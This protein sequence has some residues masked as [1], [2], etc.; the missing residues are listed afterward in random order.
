MKELKKLRYIG[1]AMFTMGFPFAQY[2]RTRKEAQDF[3][4]VIYRSSSGD[5]SRRTRIDRLR[6]AGVHIGR[7]AVQ[8]E[9][10]AENSGVAKT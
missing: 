8:F 4:L 10:F 5:G 7:V 1:W 3:A 6:D 2:F 9:W